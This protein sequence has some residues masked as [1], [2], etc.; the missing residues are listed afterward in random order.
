LDERLSPKTV[1]VGVLH[2]G[3][4]KAYPVQELHEERF[5][6]DEVGGDRVVVYS[7]PDLSL[8]GAA[9]LEPGVQVRA[10]EGRSLV[11]DNGTRVSM[12]ADLLEPKEGVTFLPVVRSYWFAWADFHRD[13]DLWSP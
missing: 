13:S 5:V 12:V 7:N 8:V 6:I 3:A 11:L 1:V 9:R 10:I 4:A 2:E